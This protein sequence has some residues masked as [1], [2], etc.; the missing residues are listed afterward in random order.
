MVLNS[1]V[2]KIKIVL[3]GGIVK[4]IIM[5]NLRFTLFFTAALLLI[6]NVSAQNLKTI[7]KEIQSS[8]EMQKDKLIETSD[9][10]WEAAETSLVEYKS[11]KQL[12]DY[13]RANGFEVTENVADIPTAFMG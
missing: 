13:A 1:K 3:L 6:I 7:K 11:A 2:Q 9:A 10:I 12:K 8:V 4:S 5:K